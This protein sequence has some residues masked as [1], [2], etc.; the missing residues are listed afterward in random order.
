MSEQRRS[1]RDA[2]TVALTFIGLAVLAGALVEAALQHWPAAWRLALSGALILIGA[3]V[4]LDVDA[5]DPDTEAVRLTG[6]VYVLRGNFGREA[7]EATSRELIARDPRA[8]LIL[9]TPGQTLEAL[10]EAEMRAA[11]WVRAEG[12][13]G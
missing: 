10:D 6:S 1:L 5:D 7:I 3:G 12:P 8:L 13:H 2:L 9:L 4:S 11:G